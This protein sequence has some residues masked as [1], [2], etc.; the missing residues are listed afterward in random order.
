VGIPIWTKHFLQRSVSCLKD[1][2]KFCVRDDPSGETDPRGAYF[3]SLI[4]A[5]NKT[6]IP[7]KRSSSNGYKE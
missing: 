4:E 2:P 5:A 3:E 6:H 7:L 1:V